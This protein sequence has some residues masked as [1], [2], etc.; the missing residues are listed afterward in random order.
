MKCS[1]VTF[2]TLS[3]MFK[4]SVLEWTCSAREDFD[5]NVCGRFTSNSILF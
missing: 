1:A 2:R 4:V 3:S 5:D